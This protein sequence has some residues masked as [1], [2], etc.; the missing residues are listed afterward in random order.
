M[1]LVTGD[2]RWWAREILQCLE[3]SKHDWVIR[4]KRLF[5]LRPDDFFF[6][7]F[8][9]FER[10]TDNDLRN[11]YFTCTNHQVLEG[12]DWYTRSV[13]KYFSPCARWSLNKRKL[14]WHYQLQLFTML[15]CFSN[16][17]SI[18]GQFILT[19]MIVLLCLVFKYVCFLCTYEEQS[20]KSVLVYNVLWSQ[21]DS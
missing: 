18:Y 10:R 9:F 13:S 1:I 14:A 20:H 2:W 21:Q 19:L 7:F 16:G 15:E 17:E 4:I 5:V 8:F 12:S 6:F 3:V 11:K